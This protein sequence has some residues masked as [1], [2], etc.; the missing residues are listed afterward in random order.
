MAL[1]LAGFFTEATFDESK[2]AIIFDDPVTSLDHMRRDKVAQRLTR[3]AK[4]RQVVVFTHDVAFVGDLT[5]AADSDGVPIIER[6]VER[7]RSDHGVCVSWLPWKA[8]DFNSR[9]D[10]LRTELAKLTKDRPSLL[11]D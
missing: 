7:R 3:L 5:A 2:S 10:H 6:S 4:D 11:Q 9:I 8:K 1:G